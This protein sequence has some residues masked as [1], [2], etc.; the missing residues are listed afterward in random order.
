MKLAKKHIGRLFDNRGSDG[1][2]AYQLIDIKGRDL[3]FYVF[4]SDNRYEIDTNDYSDWR[5]FQPTRRDKAWDVGAWYKARRS[6]YA[7]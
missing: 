5:V 2:W 7:S 6:P 3:L 4:G 1:S